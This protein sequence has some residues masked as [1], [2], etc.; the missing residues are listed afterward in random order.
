MV[1]F[2]II[3]NV[4]AP[5]N[6]MVFMDR[7]LFF[8]TVITVFNLDMPKWRLPWILEEAFHNWS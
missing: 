3:Q 5:S 8:G 4:V 1:L 2:H 7:F 6:S